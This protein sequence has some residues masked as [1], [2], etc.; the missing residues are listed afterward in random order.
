[1][2]SKT[3]KLVSMIGFLFA[4]AMVAQAQNSN[5][6][7]FDKTSFDFGVVDKGEKVSTIFHFTNTSG[8]ELKLLNID[9][10]CGCT[11]VD[12]K[13]LKAVYQP[14]QGGDIPVTFDSKR[15]TGKV[16]KKITVLVDGATKNEFVLTLTATVKPE[17][18][19]S[20]NSFTMMK[21]ER[22]EIRSQDIEF[23]AGLLDE[24]NI[25]EVSFLPEQVLTGTVSR[26]DSKTSVLTVNVD[27]SK[28]D[29]TKSRIN[30]TIKV[31]TNG[32]DMA[33][34]DIPVFI[35][36]ALPITTSPNSVYF[37]A[38][39][40]GQAR[41]MVVRYKIKDD[42]AVAFSNFRSDSD[43]ITVEK[44]ENRQAF[45][46]KLSADAPAGRLSG[47]LKIKTSLAEYPEVVIPFRGSVLE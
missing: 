34:I 27:G 20:T 14:G 2:I 44:I 28:A 40:P 12:I 18:S 19:L 21:L 7:S 13:E 22:D 36:I 24:L 45:L 35:T 10:S 47:Q 41:E 11:T 5:V 8:A 30:G 23:Q 17:I 37:F 15:F 16:L 33:K 43:Y 1:M 38:T 9:P 42:V 39:E 4:F 25:T 26:K 3:V 32:Q 6:I 29:T 31:K 46:V